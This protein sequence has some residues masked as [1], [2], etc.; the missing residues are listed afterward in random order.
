MSTGGGPR[1]VVYGQ[2]VGC[3]KGS[4][5]SGT[6]MAKDTGTPALFALDEGQ[7][8]SEHTA[9]FDALAYV[10][11]GDATARPPSCHDKV[12]SVGIC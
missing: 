2:L 10:L 1:G 3:Q 11:D 9:P 12:L 6:S 5:A 4:I 7:G 8:L